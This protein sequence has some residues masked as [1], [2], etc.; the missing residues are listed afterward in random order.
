MDRKACTEPQFLYK[1]ARNSPP[2]LY[3]A[4][5]TERIF[6]NTYLCRKIWHFI[7]SQLIREGVGYVKTQLS[8]ILLYYADDDMFRSLW[9]IFRSQNVY[10]GK[11]YGVWS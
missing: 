9:A 10:R 7:D 1:G 5:E 2:P 11:L 8:Y 6:V 4:K 3:T